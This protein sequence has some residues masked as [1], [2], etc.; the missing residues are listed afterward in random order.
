M[1]RARHVEVQLLV[2][3]HGAAL[4]LGERECSLQRR[5]QKIIEESPSPVVGSRAARATGRRSGADRPCR[6]VRRGRHR[7]VHHAGGRPGAVRLPGGQRAPAGRAPGHRAGV[8]ARPRGAAAADRRGRAA[9]PGAGGRVPDAVTRSRP[10]CAPRT[11][12]TASFPRR[13][14]SSRCASP[15]AKA[16]GWTAA[17]PPGS[18]VTPFYDSLLSKVV[19]HGRDREEALERLLRALGDLRILG[20]TTN[21]GF[22]AR[23]V[24]APQVQSGDLDTGLI[25]RGTVAERP[26]AEEADQAAVAVAAIEAQALYGHGEGG[27]PWDALVGLAGVRPRAAALGARAV[28]VSRGRRGHGRGAARRRARAASASVPGA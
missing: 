11:R 21:A 18:I 14:R 7:G 13:A 22:L 4:H 10:G 26:G 25:E 17:S 2:D 16:C 1:E 28:G 20:V 3:A 24:A 27:D 6:R 23:L 8:R 9:R 5:H 19:V 12:R 15:R